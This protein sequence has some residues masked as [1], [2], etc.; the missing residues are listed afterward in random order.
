MPIHF[1]CKGFVTT[2]DQHMFTQDSLIQQNFNYCDRFALTHP[3]IVG[4]HPQEIHL[5]GKAHQQ[6]LMEDLSAEGGPSSFYRRHESSLS[7]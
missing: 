1:R 5:K 3:C 7:N 6:V 4:F 2:T